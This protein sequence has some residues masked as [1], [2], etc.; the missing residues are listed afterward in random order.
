MNQY[1]IIY[2][3][4]DRPSSPEE[5]KKHF[6]KYQAW[7]ASLGDA[8]V[9]PMVPYG[10]SHTIAPDGTATPGSVASMSG[11][12]VIQAESVEAAVEMSRTCPF[13]ETNGSLE[14]AEL[15]EMPG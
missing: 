8:V 3:G 6:A 7:L 14:V 15:V 10:N 2:L 1:I 5:G 4:G 13:L 9:R 12:T 11:H